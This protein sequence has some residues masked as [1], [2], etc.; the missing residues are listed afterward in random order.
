[1]IVR[2]RSRDRSARNQRPSFAV[3]SLMAAQHRPQTTIVHEAQRER[4]R[5]RE[6]E[7][8]AEEVLERVSG[9]TATVGTALPPS[10]PTAAVS[11]TRPATPGAP[12]VRS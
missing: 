8:W 7:A 6:A 3:C 2:L 10:I 12:S 9:Q 1:M 5:L 4:A 11:S